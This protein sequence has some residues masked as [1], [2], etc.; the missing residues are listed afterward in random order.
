MDME[1]DGV[2]EIVVI[3]RVKPHTAFRGPNESGVAKM[4]TIGL[5]KQKGAQPRHAD[6]FGVWAEF[7]PAMARI[8]LAKTPILFGVATVENAYDR[9]AKIVAIPAGRIDRNR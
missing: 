2:D 1:S 8:T 4:I 9:I 3:N 6:G 5:G 7:I